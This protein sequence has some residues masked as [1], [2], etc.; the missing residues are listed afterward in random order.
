M[1]QLNTLVKRR[2]SGSE[3]EPRDSGSKMLAL[4]PGLSYAITKAAQVYAFVQ[5]PIY[6]HVNGIQ[7]TADWAAM[8]GV[9]SQ[10]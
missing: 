6:E 3:A 4:S 1:L 2:N 10:F 7:L 9:S 8:V 5:V